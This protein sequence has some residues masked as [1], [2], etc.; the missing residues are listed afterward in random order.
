MSQVF[1]ISFDNIIIEFE[2]SEGKKIVKVSDEE[3]L[4]PNKIKI[5][6]KVNYKFNYN[7]DF[8]EISIFKEMEPN[9]ILCFVVDHF[10][11]KDIDIQ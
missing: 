4:I 7:T 2:N 9:S 1:N 5:F 3:V 11:E 10:K 6:E 8:F